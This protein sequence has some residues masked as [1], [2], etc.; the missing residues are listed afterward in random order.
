VRRTGLV[1]PLTEPEHRS[2]SVA[3]ETTAWRDGNEWVLNGRKRW[4]GNAVWCDVIVVYAVGRDI[5]G[6]S[7]FT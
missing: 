2:D 3:L 5:T 6:Q 7:A 4:I 1:E